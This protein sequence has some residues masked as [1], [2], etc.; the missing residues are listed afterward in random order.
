[1][2]G[3]RDVLRQRAGDVS[4]WPP[5]VGRQE[6][7]RL[8]QQIDARNEA[9]WRQGAS[10]VSDDVYDQLTLRPAQ[11]RQCF[12]GATPED[13]DLPPPTG[14]TRHPVAHTGVRKLADGASVAR[15]MKSKADLWVQPKVDGVAVTPV[16]RR[17]IWFRLLAAGMACA[18]SC[19]PPERGRSRRWR[20]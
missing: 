12:P 2:A 17:G 9:Y 14:D 15:W 8:H 18:V 19:G 3:D 5:A 4:D 20:S 1:M 6:I 13:D 10:E 7:A 16:Y 11:W